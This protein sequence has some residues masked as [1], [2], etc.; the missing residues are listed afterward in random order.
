MAA[1]VLS[2]ER[3]KNWESIDGVRTQ[4]TPAAHLVAVLDIDNDGRRIETFVLQ[5]ADYTGLISE[6]ETGT[7]T[8]VLDGAIDTVLA[9]RSEDEPLSSAQKSYLGTTKSYP[10][11]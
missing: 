10:A 4:L 2:V 3:P 7:A 9:A 1:K 8:T 5:E 6:W 11:P